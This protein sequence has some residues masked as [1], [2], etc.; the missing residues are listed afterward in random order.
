MT[1]HHQKTATVA[2]STLVKPP[3]EPKAAQIPAP[4]GQEKT[5][6]V[7]QEMIR[8]RAYQKWEAAGK[9]K[10]D[11]VLFWLEAEKELPVQAK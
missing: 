10:G 5:K 6:W 8:L 9:P 4:D 2:Q 11:G 1:T 7:S 3:N